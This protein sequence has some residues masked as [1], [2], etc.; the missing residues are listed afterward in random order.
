MSVD[1]LVA[2]QPKSISV[3][4]EDLR[5]NIPQLVESLD[6]NARLVGRELVC[7]CPFH[8][9]RDSPNL[10]INSE[11]GL[12]HCWVCTQRG[13]FV[14]LVMQLR[15]G[16]YREAIG[17]LEEHGGVPTIAQIREHNLRQLES[18]LHPPH[19]AKFEDIDITPY[20]HGR[21]WWKHVRNFDDA[22][23]RKFW[24]GYDNQSRRAVI[25]IRFKE[26]WVGICKRAI[27]EYQLTKYL[28]NKDFPKERVLFGWDYVPTWENECI[29]VE[30]PTD[31]IRGHGY[32]HNNVLGLM[33]TA[34]TDGQLRLIANRFDSVIL[35]MDNDPAGA[36]ATLRN[37]ERLAGVVPRL[38]IAPFN[39]IMLKD[40]DDLASNDWHQVLQ[41]RV[42][43]TVLL[44]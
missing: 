14:Q 31:T 39:E 6:L 34:V 38:F 44:S 10:E 7:Y 33:G 25:P 11:T 28:Y 12:W 19:A 26:K 1:G 22:V 35:M 40:P 18:I 29:L 21:S 5:V 8:K 20:M 37:A 3:A 36:I 41:G 9:E 30:G 15:S 43:W 27:N 23:I 4:F 32:G 42:H 13:N 16:S 2:I 17:Y 24:L